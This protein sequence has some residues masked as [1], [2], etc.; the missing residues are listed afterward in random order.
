MHYIFL[1]ISFDGMTKVVGNDY[2]NKKL[3]ATQEQSSVYFVRG[4]T[5]TP[6]EAANVPLLYDATI[7]RANYDSEAQCSDGDIFD[8]DNLLSPTA[9]ALPGLDTYSVHDANSIPVGCVN[10]T[11]L[12]KRTD[13]HRGSVHLSGPIILSDPFPL[14]SVIGIDIDTQFIVQTLSER[15]GIVVAKL[16]VDVLLP[17]EGIPS[18]ATI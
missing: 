9:W 16:C 18:R 2:S 14:K 5:V 4:N 17:V 12:D 13:N 3:T 8:L 7:A 11:T 1:L 6:S 10:P 15:G